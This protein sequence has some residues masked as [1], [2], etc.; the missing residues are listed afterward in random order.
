MLIEATEAVSLLLLLVIGYTSLLIY[1]KGM[2]QIAHTTSA[3][4]SPTLYGTMSYCCQRLLCACI[5]ATF[6]LHPY[7]PAVPVCVP[8]NIP[9][10]ATV[11][12]VGIGGIFVPP[13]LHATLSSHRVS[14]S[15]GSVTSPKPPLPALV[16]V[17]VCMSTSG[18]TPCCMTW[19]CGLPA[20][21]VGEGQSAAGA[22]GEHH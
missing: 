13:T 20:P 9:T 10:Y 4:D 15:T 7:D 5:S 22:E 17:P 16:C 19:M 11:L 1:W 14:L 6:C 8:R 21:C 3:S 2:A 12:N 18:D